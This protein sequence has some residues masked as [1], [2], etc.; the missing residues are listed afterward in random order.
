[1]DHDLIYLTG[2]QTTLQ[3]PSDQ[4]PL[5]HMYLDYISFTFNFHNVQEAGDFYNTT[6]Y[7]SP[8]FS[9]TMTPGSYTLN[10]M[11]TRLLSGIQGDGKYYGVF[12]SVNGDHFDI[13][14]YTTLSDK[15]NNTSGLTMN[16]STLSNANKDIYSG[17]FFY[18]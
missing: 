13:I 7:L 14:Q 15:L 11:N 12:T 9:I 1:M 5:P 18:D 2:A 6:L 4:I 16:V 10:S 8:L 3:L 17:L